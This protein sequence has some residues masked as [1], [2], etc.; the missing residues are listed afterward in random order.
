MPPNA[1]VFTQSVFQ[2]LI[3]KTQDLITQR[4][5]ITFQLSFILFF[6]GEPCLKSLC[7]VLFLLTAAAGGEADAFKK[8]FALINLGVE[9]RRDIRLAST[10]PAGRLYHS[11]LRLLFCIAWFLNFVGFLLTPLR[12]C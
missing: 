5:D 11:C 9:A 3:L 6:F 8:S 1:P 12:F 7:V 10:A 2:N 4:C